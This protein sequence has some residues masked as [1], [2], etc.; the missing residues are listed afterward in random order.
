M[1]TPILKNKTPHEILPRKSPTYE[2]LQVFG[3]LANAHNTLG[4][5]NKFGEKGRPWIFIGYPM[6]QKRYKL[7]DLKDQNITSSVTFIKS[8]FPFGED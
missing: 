5:H 8:N 1:P 2:H 4:K 6:G 7:Y 3:C